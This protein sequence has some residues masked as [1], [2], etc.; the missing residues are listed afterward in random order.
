MQTQ[1]TTAKEPHIKK[2]KPKVAKSTNGK[3][4]APPRSSKPVKSNCKDK[5]RKRLKKKDSI[6]AI[7]NNAIKDKKKR[8]LGNTS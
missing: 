3:T 7:E 1:R 2:S 4:P 5:R 8:I 6:P